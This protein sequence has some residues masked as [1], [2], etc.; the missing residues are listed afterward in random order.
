MTGTCK[1]F[2]GTESQDGELTPLQTSLGF[3]GLILQRARISIGG[4]LTYLALFVLAVSVLVVGPLLFFF[5]PFLVLF[6]GADL[7]FSRL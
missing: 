4:K 5:F 3:C 6:L 2:C 1:G 7:F